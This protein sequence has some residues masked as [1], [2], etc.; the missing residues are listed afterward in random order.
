MNNAVSKALKGLCFLLLASAASSATAAVIAVQQDVMTSSFFTGT[1]RVR[2]Y[3]GDNRPVH[4]VSTDNPFGGAGAET[5][6]LT[7]DSAAIAS[8][9]GPV[10]ATLTV[11]SV[12][13]GFN[14][15]ADS[16]TP[17]LVS[18]H[19]VTANPL[20]SITD[21]TNP[22]GPVDWLT[23]FND[24]IVAADPAA[25]TSVDGFG[26]VSFDVSRIVN[27]WISG[28]NTA[29]AIALTGSD[30]I[31]GNEFLHGFLNNSNSPGASYLT[32]SAVPLPGALV[33]AGPLL[34]G[35]LHCRKRSACA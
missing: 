5:I 10:S 25:Q 26:A 11:Q 16:T 3:A 19:A 32:V 30:D 33:L 35:L 17:F 15:D 18:A 12:A 31:S 8:L 22:G 6:Y 24:Y 28:A 14:A 29:F 20:L 9:S 21:D 13:G 4:R 27:D 2:G 34:V 23:F 7:F 1:N